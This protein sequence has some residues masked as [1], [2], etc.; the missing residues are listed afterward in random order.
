VNK[1]TGKRHWCTQREGDWN[2]STCSKLNFEEDEKCII[3]GRLYKPS[4]SPLPALVRKDSLAL[5]IEKMTK[6]KNKLTTLD[7]NSSLYSEEEKQK[8]AEMDRI[9]SDYRNFIQTKLRLDR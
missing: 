5:D 1:S 7:K 9:Q 8:Q 6:E 4:P 2:C 3:C